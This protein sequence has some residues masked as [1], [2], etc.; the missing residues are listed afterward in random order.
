M[1]HGGPHAT[2][3]EE[4]PPLGQ[5]ALSPVRL[6]QVSMLAEA[7]RERTGESV[8]SLYAEL[9]EVFGVADV[10]DIPDAGWEVVLEWFGRRWQE[11]R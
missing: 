1:A 5:G 4:T 11:G 7:Q 9:A 8:A 2:G 10:I 6:V 3:A